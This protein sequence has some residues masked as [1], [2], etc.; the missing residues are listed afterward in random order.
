MISVE[1]SELFFF[2]EFELWRGATERKRERERERTKRDRERTERERG[3][4]IEREGWK[5]G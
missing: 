1:H 3:I 2:P 4:E 5:E